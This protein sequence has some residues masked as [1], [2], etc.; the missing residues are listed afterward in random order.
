MNTNYIYLI[1]TVML[2][3]IVHDSAAFSSQID[4]TNEGTEFWL[5]FE[6]NYKDSPLGTKSKNDLRIELF[7]VG[8]KESKVRIEIDGIN[9]RQEVIV[10]AGA[11]TNVPL[12]ASAQVKGLDSSERLAV[13]II[14]DNPIIVYGLSH[15]F[16]TTDTYLGLP[17]SV[18]GKEYRVMCYSYSEGL[19]SQFAIIATEDQTTVT[20]TPT[21]PITKGHPAGQPY[22]I[23]LRRGDVYQ[24]SSDINTST[25]GDLTGSYIVSDKK[26][27]VFSGHQC[28]YV[29]EGIVGCNHL[30]EQLP[31]VSTWGSHFNIGML[32][33][34]SKY[35][36]RV[37]AAQNNTKIYE[38]ST[39]VATIDAGQFY[40]NSS[41]QQNVQLTA[42][43]PILV[44]QYSQGFLNGDKLGD[45]MMLI[46]S[47]EEQ[48]LK[49]YTFATPKIGTWNH[50]VNVIVPSDA[51]E[52]L[53]LDSRPIDPTTVKI[54]ELGKYSL[55]Q[56]KIQYGSHTIVA[57]KPFGIY[58]YGLG[59]NDDAYDAYGNMGG[60]SFIEAKP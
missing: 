39:L 35:V 37:V 52:S 43:H 48:Y 38:N 24:V 7:I 9:F 46:V 28:A 11:V 5:C 25:N 18:L 45:P 41:V 22:T 14:S 54:S 23:K 36:I 4:K 34:R 50:Y 30:V 31:P 26:I 20:I 29:P 1:V 49:K 55:A 13:H 19:L 12:D 40:E 44:A 58:S 16:Q 8:N 27:A 60:Q 42:N 56:I 3:F 2:L 47:P 33:G 59:Y 57:A 51:I 15:R 6:R 10:L 17:V 53:R 21:L 32:E